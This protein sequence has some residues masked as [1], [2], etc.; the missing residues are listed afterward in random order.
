[1]SPPEA[2]VRAGDAPSGGAPVYVAS[3]IHGHPEMLSGLLR[4]AE[5]LDARDRWSGGGATLWLLGDYVDQGPDGLGVIDLAMR[6]QRE[7]AAAGGSVGALLGNHDVLLLGTRR[8]GARTFPGGQSF[9]A[10]WEANG[11]QPGD[12]A[13][14]GDEQIAWLAGLPSLARAGQRLLAHADATFYLEYGESIAATNDAV[15]AILDGE[16]MD[17]WG[18]LIVGF[19]DHRA[20]AG[21]AGAAR[22]GTLLGRFGGTQIVH[23]HT[24][25][26]VHPDTI[27]PCAPH[28]VTRPLL[29]A[30]GR[31]LDVDGGMYL[32]GPGLLVPL[33]LRTR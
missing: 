21:P 31:C 11:G 4:Q 13:G 16:D 9:A 26:S 23:G 14:L 20:F 7:A 28:D 30:G 19:S 3:D 5:L 33:P 18:R 2:P 17:A 27:P 24:P 6:L 32:G 8:F 10:A 1:V 22:A 29:Y 12:L 25:I 15:R